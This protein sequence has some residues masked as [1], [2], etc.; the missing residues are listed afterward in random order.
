MS[1]TTKWNSEVPWNKDSNYILR[2]I[3]E[4]FG[5]SKSSGKPMITLNYEVVAPE[6]M[7]VAGVTYTIAGA[8]IGL[9]QYHTTVSIDDKGNV[10][11]TKTQSLRNRLEKL[12]AAFGLDFTDFNPENPTLG[13]KGKTVY[14]LLRNNAEYQRKAPTAEML[15]KG[16]REGEVLIN[17]VT[18]KPLLFNKPEIREIF[19]L[20]DIGDK[21]Y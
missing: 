21:A 8:T 2:C 14:A 16:I 18:K 7:E 10:N 11:I 5:Q 9:T 15:A 4:T 3:E 19:G 1:E 13:F 17:P 20:A 6:T 12:Y